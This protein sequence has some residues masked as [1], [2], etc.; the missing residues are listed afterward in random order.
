MKTRF[1]AG[2][3]SNIIISTSLFFPIAAINGDV[4]LVKLLLEHKANLHRRDSEGRTPL[5]V[6]FSVT[7]SNEIICL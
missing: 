5:M 6:S 1:A 7:Y 4:R 3:K 2:C